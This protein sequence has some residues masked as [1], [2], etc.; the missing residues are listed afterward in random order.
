MASSPYSASWYR[1]AGLNPRLRSH[2]Q[3]HRQQFRGEV[4]YVLQDHASG[5][6]NQFTPAAYL[7]IGL[8]DGKN[9]VQEIWEMAAERLGDD[10]PSQDE[11]IQLLAQMH[12]ADVLHSDTQ[13][14][15]DELSERSITA[16]RKAFWQRFK[17]P[18]AIRVPLI[19]P[20]SFLDATLPFVRP[21][22]SR[23]GVA[24]WISVV[25]LA[26]F[27]AGEHWD[28]LSENVVD[29]VLSSDNIL[30]MIVVYPLIKGL[31]ELG[32]GYA[33]KV[34]GG[35]VH[36]M[37]VLFLLF[38]PVPYVD[39]S[40]SAAFRE[41]Q[42]RAIVGAAGIVVEV[43]VAS[44]ALFVWIAAEP[45][46]VRAMAFNAMFTAG[47]STLLF[48]GNPLLRFD[49]Y[50]VFVDL[51][52]IPNL[53]SRANKYFF[54][55]LQRYVY[56]SKDEAPRTARGEAPWFV[57]Y[58]IAAF[59]YRMTVM[60]GIIMLVASK[61]F[62]VGIA[63]AIWAGLT[64]F[65]MPVFKGFNFVL[66]SPR[67]RAQRSRAVGATAGVLASGAAVL[68]LIP[69]PYATMAEG[70]VWSPED[71]RVHA[72]SD[73]AIVRALAANNDIVSRGQPIIE[74]EDPLAK[75]QV[76]VIHAEVRELELRLKAAQVEDLVQSGVIE[77]KLRHSRAKLERE[78]KKVENL[79]LRSPAD[80]T[81]I[82][83]KSGDNEGRFVKKG[84]LLGFVVDYAEPIVRVIVSQADID[85]V[86]RRTQDVAVR[87]A[88][89]ISAVNVARMIREVPAAANELPSM[90]LSTQGG[91]NINIDPSET[92]KRKTFER[93]FQFD[94]G[95]NA[96]APTVRV[97]ERAYVRFSHG[98]EP[99]AWRFYRDLRQLFLRQ[100]DV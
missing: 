18:L 23:P 19:D 51:I 92:E 73:G 86:R 100:F 49:G 65:V 71:S 91:G 66:R 22:F 95:F 12:S 76:R 78:Y 46:I 84:E 27:L 81:F 55:L 42:R 70:V 68:L 62:T 34:W 3:I 33:V 20:N 53:G 16:R 77:E 44:L 93:Y 17:N 25:L 4:W 36:E 99:L 2:V 38:M 97:G 64:M 37:G 59:C 94:I 54:Y 48:N 29:Q 13:S 72:K 24:L 88:G 74:M 69:L 10:L 30:M 90:V 52:E 14:D 45:G 7:M 75:S 57:F 40:A 8:M 50:Y 61:F 96:G 47:V 98:Y 89:Q 32:H 63:M 82:L 39:A 1:V 26:V 21:L 83:P 80:G 5:R 79:I 60:T 28:A 31:H 11:V 87:F 35:E 85:L 67:L 6:F 56:G 58:S 43:F 9:T 15:V 41:K